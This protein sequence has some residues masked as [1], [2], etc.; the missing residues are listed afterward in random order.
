MSFPHR[1]QIYLGSDSISHSVP[2][3]FLSFS[4]PFLN[5]SVSVLSFSLLMFFP[6]GPISHAIYGG[7]G[8]MIFSAYIVYDTDK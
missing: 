6:L 4:T 2:T 8:A 3:Q 5:F 1:I 7:V